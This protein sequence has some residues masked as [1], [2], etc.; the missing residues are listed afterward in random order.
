MSVL[1]LCKAV[2][3]FARY[4]RI[5]F[6][7]KNVEFSHYISLNRY[8]YNNFEVSSHLEDPE[9]LNMTFVCKGL[10]PS[11][12]GSIRLSTNGS[13][14]VC[15]SSDPPFTIS[16]CCHAA[17]ERFWTSLATWRSAKL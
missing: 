2:F 14:V 4:K 12:N 17:G 6:A 8:P 16:S 3:I 10:M 13:I 1:A 7:F 11:I 5:V 9:E 15:V